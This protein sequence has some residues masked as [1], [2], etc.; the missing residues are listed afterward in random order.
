[1]S[2]LTMIQNVCDLL[3]LARPSTVATSSDQTVRQLFALAKEEGHDL[4]S[5]WDWQA[6]QVQISF[7]TVATSQQTS[8]SF[9]DYDRWVPNTFWNQTTRRPLLGPVTPQVWQALQAQPAFAS[10]YLMWRIRQSAFYIYPVPP[11]GQTIAGEYI[12]TQWAKTAG[13]S[14][15]TEWTNDT[16]T[17]YLDEQLM[18]LGIRWRFKAAKGLSYTEDFQTYERN[19]SQMMSRDKSNSAIAI[20]GMSN[21]PWGVN[22]PEGSINQ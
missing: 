18:A 16:D 20:A 22:L 3:G 9:S 21:Y 2:L 6:L 7:T 17:S 15:L 8:L 5:A 11:A 14:G 1:M 19:K 13:G 4:Q 12:S 10:I